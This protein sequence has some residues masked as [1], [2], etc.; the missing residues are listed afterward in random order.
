MQ[1]VRV[2]MGKRVFVAMVALVLLGIVA[3]AQEPKAN[4]AEA[5]R[6]AAIPQL[7]REEMRELA[8]RIA[9][10]DVAN[11]QK[12]RN[13]TFVEHVI[14]RKLNG[15]G[16][17]KSTE[18]KTYEVMQL[19]GEQVNRLVEKDGK[20]LSAKE[21]EKEEEKIQKLIKKRSS[22]SESDRNKRLEKEAKAR[23]EARQFVLEVPDAYDLKVIG[24]ERIHGRE[25]LV[26]DGNPRPDYR[27]RSKDM[28]NAMKF[29]LR[30]W[31]DRAAEQWVKV[32]VEAI[33]NLSWGAFLVK[34]NKGTTFEMEQTQVNQ[35]VWL[36]LH[37]ELKLGGRALFKSLNLEADVT[38]RDYKKFRS[39][40]KISEPSELVENE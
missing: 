6:G 10:N 2:L 3:P 31:V 30:A 20:P 16:G 15:D 40:V 8:R 22:E 26:I 24:I 37:F 38:F 14:E 11:N 19:Y 33:D 34:I 13:Y 36:P 9:E 17:V 29:K 32:T 1:H 28:K 27:P 23:E 39:D 21:A 25:L 4:E 12:V 18:S 5:E 7:T 35:E